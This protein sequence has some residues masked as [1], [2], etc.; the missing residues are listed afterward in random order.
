MGVC[1]LWQ[2]AAEPSL[3]ETRERNAKAGKRQEGKPV[4][5]L[6]EDDDLDSEEELPIKALS[7]A[8]RENLKQQTPRYLNCHLISTP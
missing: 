1:G 5:N 8:D 3:A 2:P 4:F 6:L 7:G